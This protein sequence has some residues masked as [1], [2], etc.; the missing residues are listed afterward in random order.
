MSV[1]VAAEEIERETRTVLEDYRK[2]ARIPGFRPGKAPLSVIRSHF[3]KELEEDVRER[4][5]SASFFKATKE[6]GLEPL[7]RPAVE[8]VSH[9][10]GQPLTFNTVFEVLPE[11]EP[12]GYRDV[13]VTR[14]VAK[15]ADD[16][17]DRALEEIRQARVQLVMEDGRKAAMGDVVY[18]D[19]EGS[20]PEGEPFRRER[21]PIEIGSENNIKE[22]NEKLLGT[23]P[24]AE[25]E[26]PVE[27]AEDYGAKH[28]AGKRVEYRLKVLEVK[29][30]VLPDL[31]DELAKDLG[32][33]DDLDALRTKVRADLE[34]RKKREAELAAR[35]AVLDKVLIE[36]PVVL[37]DVLVEQ[38]MRNRL[39]EF[40]RNLIMQGVDPEKAKIDWEDLRKRQEEPARK[41]V[42]ARLI[43][44]AVARLEKIAVDDT[45]FDER[46][47][48]DAKRIGESPAS[49]RA[50]LEKHSSK[51][52]LMGQLVREKS[53]DYLTSV[54]NIQYAD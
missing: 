21:L 13:E 17:V 36:N 49:L 52:A 22:F 18:A 33:F 44:D 15:V 20:P 26:F 54:A 29:R 25:L 38:E 40:V 35:E 47:R 14:S 5:V 32:D 51:E 43:L 4:I 46:I 28:L 45:E 16:E 6:K 8:D 34:T 19:V 31:D 53:L 24:G 42:H 39:E 37:P 11:I 2:K 10:E 48:E 27:Y 12:K 41:S 50:R 9:E 23:L 7:G 1:E 30:P 3:T